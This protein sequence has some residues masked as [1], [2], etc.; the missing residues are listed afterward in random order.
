MEEL[1]T[2]FL[3]AQKGDLSDY[4]E[5]V[6]RFQDMAVGYGYAIL[7]DFHL[8]QD[9][10]QEAFT[11]AWVHLD[12]VHSLFAFPALLRKIV[13]KHCDR[14]TRRGKNVEIISMEHLVDIKSKE[15]S[16]AQLAEEHEMQDFIRNAIDT[17]PESE[18]Q[19]VSLYYIS[20]YSQQEVAAFLGTDLHRQK[21]AEIGPQAAQRK[22]I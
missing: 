1:E 17:L 2:T 21:S 12:R 11:E 5:I 9:A 14:F 6:T 22:V 15:K 18:Q 4:D 20:D 10:A 19:T 8:A 16:P 3:H 13:F 7:K